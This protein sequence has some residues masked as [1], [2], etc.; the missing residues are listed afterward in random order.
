MYALQ[1][2][3]Q[4]VSP[5]TRLGR[6]AVLAGC[7]DGST[8]TPQ[9]N[10]TATA[11][12]TTSSPATPTPAPDF[13]GYLDDVDNYDGTVTDRRGRDTITV[14]VG[15]AAN[16][17]NFGFGPPAVHID[18]GTTVLF[19]WTGDGGAHS[20]VSE[21]DGPLDSGGVFAELGVHYEYT[22][23]SDGLYPY[24]CEPHEGLGMHGAIVVGDDYP[25]A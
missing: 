25:A 5:D 23:E 20:V 11:T 9:A 19:K 6:G 14:E 3:S 22:F 2:N 13:D 7:A 17:G 16:G 4:S 10:E 1:P 21:D 12:G 24:H 18:T 8:A 15:V